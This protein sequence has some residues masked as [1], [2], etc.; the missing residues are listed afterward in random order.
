MSEHFTLDSDANVPP[1]QS[2]DLPGFRDMLRFGT[3]LVDLLETSCLTDTILQFPYLET[4]LL[5]YVLVLFF[6]VSSVPPQS[7]SVTLMFFSSSKSPGTGASVHL[8]F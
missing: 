5:L 6:D 2:P 3:V 8:L 1:E 7:F 4:F